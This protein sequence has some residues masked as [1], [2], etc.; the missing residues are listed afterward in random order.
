MFVK[1]KMSSKYVKSL[2][3][4]AVD[5]LAIVGLDIGLAMILKKIGIMSP[6]SFNRIDFEDVAKLYGLSVVSDL[7]IDWLKQNDYWPKI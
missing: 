6:P 1:Y 5:G 7:T 3:D 4:S 2:K